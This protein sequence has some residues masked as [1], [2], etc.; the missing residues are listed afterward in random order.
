MKRLLSALFCCSILAMTVGCEKEAPAESGP[1]AQPSEPAAEATTEYNPDYIIPRTEYDVASLFAQQPLTP[2][3]SERIRGTRNAITDLYD[4]IYV[5]GDSFDLEYKFIERGDYSVNTWNN[6]VVITS[7]DKH[8]QYVIAKIAN[9]GTNTFF[10]SG[11]PQEIVFLKADMQEIK[12]KYSELYSIAREDN[13]EHTGEKV[14]DDS[15]Y[16]GYYTYTPFVEFLQKNNLQY[17]IPLYTEEQV[18]TALK[19]VFPIPDNFVYFSSAAQHYKNFGRSG[20]FKMKDNALRSGYQYYLVYGENGV[21]AVQNFY[22]I[23]DD[24]YSE[25]DFLKLFAVSHND[26]DVYGIADDIEIEIKAEVL[27]S[28]EIKASPVDD[29]SSLVE[30]IY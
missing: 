27:S 20:V 4:T 22:S 21:Y 10:E 1:L 30:W 26:R 14:Y 16:G 7:G 9:K 6:C 13:L 8:Q 19:T 17:D 18:K 15:V 23:D 11:M 28:E 29:P 5:N 12:D 3:M 25:T 24:M 2:S